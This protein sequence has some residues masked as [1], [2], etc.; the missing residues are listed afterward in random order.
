M[1]EGPLDINVLRVTYLRG[2][3]MWTYRSVL[4]AWLDLG[5]LENWPSNK[6]PGF[7]DRLLAVLPQVAAHHCS[8]GVAYGFEQRL[9][10]GRRARNGQSCARN[11]GDQ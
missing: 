7:I 1:P 11:R 5:E 6:Q 9:R 3:N 2:P 8:P 4:E 10:D